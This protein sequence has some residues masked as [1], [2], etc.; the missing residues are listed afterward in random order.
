[1]MRKT[2][3]SLLSYLGCIAMALFVAFVIEGTIGMVLTY[4]LIIALIASLLMT[5]AVLRSI[6]VEAVLTNTA[7]SKGERLFCQMKI[8]NRS[9]LPAPPLQVE[10]E[11]S[12]HFILE[13]EN[14]LSGSVTGKG[15]NCLSFPLRALHSGKARIRIRQLR[16]TDYLGIFSFG[17]KYDDAVSRLSVAVYPNIPPVSLQTSFLR[18]TGHF[19][20]DEEDEEESNES[21]AMPTGLAGYD[22]RVYIPGDPIKRINWKMSSK[23][24]ILMVRLDEQIKGSGRVILLDIPEAELNNHTLIVRDNVIEGALALLTSLLNEGREALFYYCKQGLWICADIK[25]VTD[26]Y[27]LQE[28]LSDLEADEKASVMPPA[29]M[30]DAKSPICFTAATGSSTYTAEYIAAHRPDAIIIASYAASL[31]VISASQWILS[32]GFDLGR[33]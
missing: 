24:D 4:A 13:G 27:E 30:Q 10:I 32:E 9:F 8:R 14:V 11:A 29:L 17:I 16:L 31:P 5:L 26:I 12:A 1:M 19:A 28:A 20:R 23:R 2:L 21:S 7:L 33:T 22:H 15:V 18:S 6:H 25:N 3:S